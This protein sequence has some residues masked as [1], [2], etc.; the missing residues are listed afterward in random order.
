MSRRDLGLHRLWL[1]LL[2]SGIL[3]IITACSS[4]APTTHT[5]TDMIEDL[6]KWLS[7]EMGAE[8]NISSWELY[9]PESGEILPESDAFFHVIFTVGD[10]SFDRIYGLTYGYSRTFGWR[11][12]DVISVNED[13][14]L[15]YTVTSVDSAR[16]LKD[17]E[18]LPYYSSYSNGQME[19]RRVLSSQIL[20]RETDATV[21]YDRITIQVV[22]NA[23]NVHEVVHIECEYLL[24][25]SYCWQLFA[26][27]MYLDTVNV[28]SGVSDEI[29]LEGL[30]TLKFYRE[31]EDSTWWIGELNR[32]TYEVLSRD[33]DSDN[34]EE[35]IELT[36]RGEGQYMY[37]T[38][39]VR[40]DFRFS[41]GWYL[42]DIE[43]QEDTCETG[44]LFDSWMLTE[45]QLL[46]TLIE[47][48]PFTYDTVHDFPLTE[49]MITDLAITD[50]RITEN[51]RFQ[52]AYFSYNVHV[53][54]AIFHIE[55]Y[56]KYELT[57]NGILT[58]N[59]WND[60]VGDITYDLTGIWYACDLTE[61]YLAYHTL[62][63]TDF[64][65]GTLEGQLTVYGVDLTGK[66]PEAFNATCSVLGNITFGTQFELFVESWTV[67]N[68]DSEILLPE[69][70][71]DLFEN[72]LVNE[73]AYSDHCVFTKE[74]P[75]DRLSRNEL[76][77][78]IRTGNIF[79]TL[80]KLLELSKTSED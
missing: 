7:E 60:T 46:H 64:G 26:Q 67:Q 20:E 18:G 74:T 69:G 21:G 53:N 65:N 58:V 35:I 19:T 39:E 71:Y 52:T 80:Q 62:K 78:R 15:V 49:D 3:C 66:E 2:L 50:I 10:I 45:E 40:L 57:N 11:L 75:A 55:G 38:G 68:G 12:T 8:V 5:D 16:I 33:L 4:S 43:L 28:Q 73:H 9:S 6:R 31:E 56:G 30:S 25:E 76:L 61:E 41:S 79:E 48:R 29:L 13:R 24:D 27:D 37:I 44:M 42:Y 72:A 32:L 70:K 36:F 51:G 77:S 63:L 1:I 59:T 17:L 14:W 54:E 47:E 23:D 34:S 22:L